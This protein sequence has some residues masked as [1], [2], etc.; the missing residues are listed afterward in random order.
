[1]E[2]SQDKK[3]EMEQILAE[4]G[5]K[6]DEIIQKARHASGDLQQEF[7]GKLDELNRSK[8]KLEE[9]LKDFTQDE[10]KWK[11]V[12]ARLQNAAHELRQAIELSFKRKPKA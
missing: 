8:E 5:R 4:L 7:S 1:M 11:E 10:A 3:G 12:Q 2:T 9:E 6:M